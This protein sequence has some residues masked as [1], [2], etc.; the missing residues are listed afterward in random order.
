[1]KRSVLNFKSASFSDLTF[2]TSGFCEYIFTVVAS[3][4]C[5]G[6]AKHYIGFAATSA[7]NIHKI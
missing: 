7:L 3:D 1:M 5:L 4:N 2:S 6:M